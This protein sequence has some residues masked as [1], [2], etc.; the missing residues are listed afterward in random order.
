MIQTI[1]PTYSGTYI[2]IQD[3]TS[4]IFAGDPDTIIEGLTDGAFLLE[5][6]GPSYIQTQTLNLFLLE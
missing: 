3:Q 4:A 1:T 5:E 6:A 2:I